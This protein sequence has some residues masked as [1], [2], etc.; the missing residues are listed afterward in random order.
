MFYL[1]EEGL[2]AHVSGPSNFRTWSLQ[3]KNCMLCKLSLSSSKEQTD[4][5][6]SLCWGQSGGLTVCTI[7]NATCHSCWGYISIKCFFFPG[8]LLVH[9][10]SLTC[11][12]MTFLVLKSIYNPLNPHEIW[13][14]V[15]NLCVWLRKELSLIFSFCLFIMTWVWVGISSLLF[16]LSIISTSAML[17][18]DCYFRTE[19]KI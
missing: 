5:G 18:A 8:T 10:R 17:R 12:S 15:I 1:F 11:T 6:L 19:W 14:P 13:S 2:K 16:L 4:G 3:T 9:G 7:E